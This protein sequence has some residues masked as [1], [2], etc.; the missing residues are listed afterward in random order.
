[1][2]DFEGKI[3]LVTGAGSGIGRA[4][5]ELYARGGA[6]VVAA[7]INDAS[8]ALTVYQIR[9]AGGQALFCHTDVA[10]AA[11]CEQLVRFTVERFGTIMSLVTSC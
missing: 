7:D 5:A 3:A 9:S 8:G 2:A 4:V 11:E 10:E 1:M 6:R